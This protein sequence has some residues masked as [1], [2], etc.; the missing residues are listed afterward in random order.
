MEFENF[1]NELIEIYFIKGKEVMF[2]LRIRWIENGEKFMKYFFNLEKWN[3]EK[4]III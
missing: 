3:Y 4:K 1:K 2:R